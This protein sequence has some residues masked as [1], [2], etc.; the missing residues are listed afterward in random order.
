[1]DGLLDGLKV[2]DLSSVLAGPMTGSFLAECGAEVLKVEAPGG[3]VT[4]TWR[5]TGE[6]KDRTSAYHAAA[7]TGKQFAKCNLKTSKGRDWMSATLAD[8]DVLIQNMKWQDLAL[9]DLL[10]HDLQAR[11]PRLV[12]V[13]LIGSEFDPDR[14]AYDVVVQAESGFM[15]MNGHP[16][17][18]PARLP[19]ALMD[20]LASHHMRAAVLAGLYRRE[21]TGQGNYAEVSL[22]GAGLTALANQATN[23]LINGKVPQRQGSEHPNIAP[24]GD[25]LTC[26]DGQIVLAV[27]SDAQ[28][29][30]LCRTLKR[31][32]LI[33]SAPFKSN[34]DRL[35]H[36][37]DLMS[38]LNVAA[39]SFKR[40]DLLGELLVNKVPSGAILNVK[41]ALDQPGI[42]S[43]YVV[44]EDGLN[45][46]KT[47]A[48]APG[49]FKTGPS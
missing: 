48:I 33:E 29:A 7:N 17:R 31:P 3:D 47:S 6:P 14:L 8:A 45:R 49:G 19:V 40:N 38:A 2:V 22:L 5:V 28:F 18:S 27:G 26:S 34:T 30:S 44:H 15:S 32:D 39:Q 1:M 46:M 23:V 10:P 13:R 43:T 37:K 42:R 24:Y 12:H 4:Q 36:R 16:D 11:F 20:V 25:V 9:M 41:E 35:K 21:R